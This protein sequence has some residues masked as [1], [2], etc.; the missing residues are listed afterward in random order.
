MTKK[1][2]IPVLGR[3]I[4]AR[5]FFYEDKYALS[6]GIEEEYNERLHND[7]KFRSSLWFWF[8]IM[9]VVVQYFIFSLNRSSMMLKNYLISGYRNFFRSKLTSIINVSGLSLGLASTI[10]I[11]L[12]IND[13]ISFDRFHERADRIYSL[14]NRDNYFEYT[15]RLVPNG[16]GPTMEKYF[17]EIEQSMRVSS[18]GMVVRYKDKIFK[19]DCTLVDPGFFEFFSFKLIK[20]DPHNVLSSVNAIVLTESAA[21]RYFGN[22]EPVGKMVEIQKGQ[23][24][25]LFEVTGVV[26]NTPDN[27]SI[28]YGQLINIS[29]LTDV[30]GPEAL[31]TLT[32]PRCRTYVLL[33]DDFSLDW[34]NGRMQSYVSQYFA[35]YIEERKQSGHWKDNGIMIEFLL[36]NIMDIH[37][38]SSGVAAEADNE[39]NKTY[40]LASIGFLVLVIAGI[41]FTNL[42][43]GKAA[44]RATE[45]GVR[46]ILG[47]NRRNLIRQFWGESVIVIVLSAVLSIILAVLVLPLFNSLAGKN[48]QFGDFITIKNLMIFTLITLALGFL[49][50]SYPGLIMSSFQPAAIFRKK[51][52]PVGRNVM[53]K[54]LVIMQFSISIFLVIATLTMGK[55]IEFIDQADL[56]YKKE[57]I[58]V[59]ETQERVFSEGE[60][61]IK[62]FRNRTEGDIDI[63]NVSGCVYSLGTHQGEGRWVI[64]GIRKRFNFSHVYHGYFDVMGMS[65]VDGKDFSE[66]LTTD[67]TEVLVN[68]EFV[69]Q[70]RLKN[71]VG[72]MI[73]DDTK[74]AGIVKDFNYGSLKDDIEPVIHWINPAG[75]LFT[76]LVSISGDDLGSTI[77]KLENIWKEIQP[78]K[79]FVY[80]FL[81]DNLENH[82][83]EDRKWN[84]IVLYSSI[85]TLLITCLG[86][87]GITTITVNRRIKE[88][89]IKKILGAS[90]PVIVNLL[91]KEF[92]VLVIISNIIVW[93]AGYYIM[94]RWLARFAFRTELEISSFFT[95][96][97]LSLAVALI[98]VSFQTLKAA[99]SN[100]VDTLKCEL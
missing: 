85:F 87:I 21:L 69:K 11:I 60:R 40:I 66:P 28:R 62:Y 70:F 27:S 23:L 88:I 34:I 57:N 1:G 30:R 33:R 20:G 95:A 92:F 10:L 61:V 71:P 46:K 15:Y 13:E 75:S 80:S 72:M 94:N 49:S 8:Q 86:L 81:H 38:H 67:Y 7:G 64:N 97:I 68:Q 98:T 52:S 74:I 14:I 51:H 48:L 93:P 42:A 79:P 99:Y 59:I 29:N 90:L 22:E 84:S 53:T 43:I 96:G 36:Q 16:T 58:M 65:I 6:D 24:T 2:G 17:D 41:N 89:G 26:E 50:G 12:F 55:Q 9:V 63:H 47:A 35:E 32:W 54:A 18:L 78:N 39:V 4:L 25:E 77:S 91:S 44:V 31:T 19:E 37:L 83:I 73:S 56:G 3:K 5:I 100:P 45:I 82:Y 76:L